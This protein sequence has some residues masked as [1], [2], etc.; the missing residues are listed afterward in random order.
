MI[1]RCLGEAVQVAVRPTE[2]T[3]EAAIDYV[4]TNVGLRS[5]RQNCG[6]QLGGDVERHVGKASDVVAAEPAG[7]AAP[8]RHGPKRRERHHRACDPDVESEEQVIAVQAVLFKLVGF[9]VEVG[10]RSEPG[11]E[12][13]FDDQDLGHLVPGDGAEVLVV[14]VAGESIVLA[15]IQLGGGGELKVPRWKVADDLD[16]VDAIQWQG[17]SPS[18]VDGDNRLEQI[19]NPRRGADVAPHWRHA[20]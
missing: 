5:Q 12:G 10:R 14:L 11:D 15:A 17:P 9:G 2:D 18:G 19:M 6:G 20:R 1:E 3:A 7:V 4:E 13:G 8:D 16:R